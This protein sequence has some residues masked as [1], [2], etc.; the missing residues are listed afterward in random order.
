MRIA[1][2]LRYTPSFSF[3]HGLAL[4][5]KDKSTFRVIED[6]GLDDVSLHG[7]A[8]MIFTVMDK[9]RICRIPLYLGTCRQ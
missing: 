8:V 5:W 7:G 3:S 4:F 9:I 6:Q 2:G 1:R